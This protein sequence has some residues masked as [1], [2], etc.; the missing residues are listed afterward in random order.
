MQTRWG[1]PLV[2]RVTSEA[3]TWVGTF[4]AGLGGVTGVFA[5]PSPTDVC[6]ISGGWAYL[7]DTH[8]PSDGA[9]IGHRQVVQVEAAAHQL[10]LLVGSLDIVAVGSA[11]IAWA[12]E[13]LAI[14]G[15]AVVEATSEAITC[16]R[17][18]TVVGGGID[19][20]VLDAATGS[21][22]EGSPLGLA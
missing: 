19:T 22:V 10:L 14:D 2:M 7:M 11:G 8:R 4:A 20:F 15:L 17:E 21:L 18:M 16:T 9:V 5:C 3:I 6:A 12:S 1:P 13:R